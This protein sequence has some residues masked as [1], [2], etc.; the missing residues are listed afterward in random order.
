MA[1]Y[2]LESM[3]FAITTSLL[4]LAS[5]SGFD[6]VPAPVEAWGPDDARSAVEPRPPGE[7]R[8]TKRKLVLK[9]S[10]GRLVRSAPMDAKDLAMCHNLNRISTDAGYGVPEIVDAT[11][12]LVPGLV[13]APG[14]PPQV[15]VY[16]VRHA[17]SVW[18]EKQESSAVGAILS[19]GIAHGRHLVSGMGAGGDEAPTLIDA[20]LTENGIQQVLGLRNWIASPPGINLD[21]YFLSGDER[22]NDETVFATSN[23]RRAALTLLTAF[24]DQIKEGKIPEVHILSALQE[25]S[26]GPDS[27]SLTEPG[28]RP[29]FSFSSPRFAQMAGSAG[30]THRCPFTAA[31]LRTVFKPECN[32]GDELS[33]SGRQ[34]EGLDPMARFCRWASRQAV[35]HNKRTFVIVGHSHWFRALMKLSFGSKA[36]GLH[37]WAPNA[38]EKAFAG[39]RKI[40]NSQVVKFTLQLNPQQIGG[41]F[42][43]CFVVPDTTSSVYKPFK[44]TATSDE[45]ATEK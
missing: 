28:Q 45:S 41:E 5:G 44:H 4:G 29:A 6:E 35:Y 33:L 42:R 34:V 19:A 3:K 37:H 30:P 15:T 32:H 43:P 10:A 2:S 8:E 31:E 16:F 14:E 21:K 9:R 27:V 11:C 13:E 23:L 7:E 1:R 40:S 36:E 20:P 12:D 39:R 38:I 18:N 26:N 25:V 22:N 24:G 17:E